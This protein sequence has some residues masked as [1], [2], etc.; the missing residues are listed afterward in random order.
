TAV[1][2]EKAY[3][4]GVSAAG[5]A[6][7]ITRACSKGELNECGCDNAIRQRKPRGSWEWGG[8]S[9]D[10][11]FGA[12][13]S[14]KFV[15]AGEDAATAQGLMN[16][17]NNEAGRRKKGVERGLCGGSLSCFSFFVSRRNHP[18]GDLDKSLTVYTAHVHKQEHEHRLFATPIE[19][20]SLGEKDAQSNVVCLFIS[21]LAVLGTMGRACNNT[22]YGMDGC[23]LLC[24]GRG[25]QT[26]VREV[27]EKCHCKFVWCCKVQ[28]QTCR[29]TKE[30][31][32]CK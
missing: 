11:G 25:Y 6:Y 23:R 21:R 30:E 17:H 26:V 9:D 2:R 1:S 32:F 8:C 28:C 16:L 31:H 13:F 27:D 10:I 29:V 5:V 15:D 4:Y 7:S 3:V 22:S 14:R 24:C 20:A 12:Q 19:R 18:I